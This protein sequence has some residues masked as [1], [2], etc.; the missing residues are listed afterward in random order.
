MVVYISSVRQGRERREGKL[1]ASRDN[2]EERERE[3]CKQAAE[4]ERER[5]CEGLYH[6]VCP[7]DILNQNAWFKLAR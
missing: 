6:I 4:R 7:V 3:S 1:V 5:R 2:I